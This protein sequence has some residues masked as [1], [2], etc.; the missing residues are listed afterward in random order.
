LNEQANSW[1]RAKLLSHGFLIA[2]PWNKKLLKFSRSSRKYFFDGEPVSLFMLYYYPFCFDRRFSQYKRVSQAYRNPYEYS[3]AVDGFW[4]NFFTG[5][6]RRWAQTNPLGSDLFADKA[7]VAFLPELVRHYLHKKAAISK[8]TYM[9]LVG[10]DGRPARDRL[11][12][13]FDNRS[14]WVIK[15]RLDSGMGVGVFVGR[16]MAGRKRMNDLNWEQLRQRVSK[17]P[18][19]YVAQELV[20]DVPI[21]GTSGC[22]V[23]FEMRNIVHTFGEDVVQIDP[24]LMR[25][26]PV[27]ETRSIA[28]NPNC[29]RVHVLTR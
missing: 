8:S 1:L 12:M 11:Q 23:S 20:E 17:F 9:T 15:S 14:R 2:G 7:V 21:I 28:S 29:R 25:V 5:G 10:E 6:F 18:M 16:S 4:T 13:V 3:H 27:G 24:L 19:G 26:A 22:P